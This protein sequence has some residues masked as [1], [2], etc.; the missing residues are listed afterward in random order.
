[1]ITTNNKFVRICESRKRKTFFFKILFCLCTLYFVLN[2]SVSAQLIE[3]KPSYIYTT[4][5]CFN[6]FY[7]KT[8]KVK[9]ITALLSDKPDNQI[10]VDKGLVK[11]YEFDTAGNVKRFYF[12]SV[13]TY[14]AVEVPVPAVYKKGKRISKATTVTEYHYFYDTTFTWFAYDKTGRVTMKRTNVG[15]IF[16]TSYYEYNINGFF[17]KETVCKETNKG[18]SIHS[19]ELGVQTVIS[20]ESFEYVFQ[21]PSQLKRLCL[22]DEGKVYKEGIINF[23]KSQL[24][25]N[26]A[27]KVGYVR[28]SNLY[29]YDAS[30]KMIKQTFVPDNNVDVKN[31]SAFEYSPE[32]ILMAEKKYKNETFT[33]NIVYSYNEK[34]NLLNSRLNRDFANANIGITKFVYEFW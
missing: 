4:D 29:E 33:N 19:F 24:E 9:K 16:N 21:S 10:I 5:I 18:A 22:N 6:S 2:T 1:M 31:I 11:C 12:T 17:S 7:V 14:E 20:V 34:T 3:N 8:S 32:G 13:K 28:Y 30:G 27:Y 15:D 25:E 26:Y 23:S